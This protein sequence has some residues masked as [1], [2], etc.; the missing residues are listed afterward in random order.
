MNA[1]VAYYFAGLG[2]STPGSP[3]PRRPGRGGGE[4]RGRLIALLAA[5]AVVLASALGAIAF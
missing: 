2:L 4:P 3:D 5:V 1:A